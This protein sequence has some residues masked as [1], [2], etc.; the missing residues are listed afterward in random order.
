MGKA[1]RGLPLHAAVEWRTIFGE[2]RL[3][4]KAAYS[5]LPSRAKRPAMF[6]PEHEHFDVDPPIAA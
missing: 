6:L 5:P 1:L 4:W 2:Q 3:F